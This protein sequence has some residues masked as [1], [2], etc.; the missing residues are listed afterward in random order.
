MEYI[1]LLDKNIDIILDNNIFYSILIL[2]LIIY[3]T[4]SSYN[5]NIVKLSFDNT[6]VKILIILCILYFSSKDLRISLLLTI[7]FL[8]ELDKLH[9]KEVNDK[10]ALFLIRDANLEEKNKP[11][12]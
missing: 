9:I 1:E 5:Q 11:I 7:I 2:G 10:I 6:L 8:I 3:C 12:I 4:F